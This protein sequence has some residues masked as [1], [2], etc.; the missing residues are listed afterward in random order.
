MYAA[1]IHDGIPE[2]KLYELVSNVVLNNF[3]AYCDSLFVI[4]PKL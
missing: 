3:V 4:E 2:K 1:C